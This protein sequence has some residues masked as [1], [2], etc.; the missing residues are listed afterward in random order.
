MHAAD[1]QDEVRVPGVPRIA[2]RADAKLK[3]PPEILVSL[4]GVEHLRA[5]PMH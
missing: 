4:S 3:D 1:A 2:W 5:V